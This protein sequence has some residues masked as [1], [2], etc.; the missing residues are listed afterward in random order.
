MGSIGNSAKEQF[1]ASAG[2][3]ARNLIGDRS[4]GGGKSGPGSHINRHSHKQHFLDE[5]SNT[6]EGAKKT[7]G[8]YLGER[9]NEGENYGLDYMAKKEARNNG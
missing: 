3:L 8:E 1:K 2:D 9:R 7:F 5:E 6:E 4:G